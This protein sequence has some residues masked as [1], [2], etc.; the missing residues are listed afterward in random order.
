[1]NYELAKKLKEAGF[2][3]KD[4]PVEFRCVCDSQNRTHPA[5]GRCSA[6]LA[7]LEELID[8]CGDKFV[9]L[10]RDLDPDVLWTAYEIKDRKYNFGSTPIEAVGRLWLALNKK[11]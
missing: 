2:P 1:M 3:Q 8:A 10:E 9:S 5:D 4:F 6:Y 7:P 11:V